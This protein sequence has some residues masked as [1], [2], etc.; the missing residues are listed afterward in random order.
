M[1]RRKR[2]STRAIRRNSISAPFFC[3]LFDLAELCRRKVSFLN[4]PAA[5]LYNTLR[6]FLR[7]LVLPVRPCLPACGRPPFLAS[8]PSLQPSAFGLSASIRPCASVAVFPFWQVFLLCYRCVSPLLPRGAVRSRRVPGRREPDAEPSN[9]VTRVWEVFD[10][11][12][13]LASSP[14]WRGT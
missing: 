14:R 3:L 9:I 6:H 1:S 11:R 5:P 12:T 13:Y 10:C 8:S 7:W 4:S 2:T